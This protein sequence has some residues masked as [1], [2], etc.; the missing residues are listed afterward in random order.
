MDKLPPIEW[1]PTYQAL[2]KH[3]QEQQC[4]NHRLPTEEDILSVN[5]HDD[6]NTCHTTGRRAHDEM[7]ND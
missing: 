7:N 5:N 6:N 2:L 3:L 1:N 4:L